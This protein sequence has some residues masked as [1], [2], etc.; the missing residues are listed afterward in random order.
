MNPI[1][2][3]CAPEFEGVRNAFVQN[4]AEGDLG[5][6]YGSW[7]SARGVAWPLG[8]MVATPFAGRLCD[9][10]GV[11]RSTALAFALL[12]FVFVSMAFVKTEFGLI[13]GFA[14]FGIAM[15]GVDVGWSL[16]P[17]HFAPEGRS[18]S[19]VGIHVSMVGV[20]SL[21]APFF[22]YTMLKEFGFQTACLVAASM[23]M[24]GS[25]MLWLFVPREPARA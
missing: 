2:G 21:F 3:H 24:C 11:V 6:S 18:R 1:D 16:G 5:L 7:T 14:F 9:K 10:I 22:G 8:I 19:Y 20:R 12:G 15:A 25:A 4:F 17:L 23:V 13:A